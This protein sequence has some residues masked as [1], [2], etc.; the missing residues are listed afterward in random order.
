MAKN[1]TETTLKEPTIVIKNVTQI[2]ESP[3]EVS[4]SESVKTVKTVIPAGPPQKPLNETVTI[5]EPVITEPIVKV[6][7]TVIEE[8]DPSPTTMP[9]IP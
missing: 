5:K 6:N 3:I 9:K 4:E 8:V 2:P 1:Q 7:V